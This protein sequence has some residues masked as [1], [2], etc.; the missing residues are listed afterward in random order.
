MFRV[1]IYGRWNVELCLYD[2]FVSQLVTP[3]IVES[4]AGNLSMPLLH[5]TSTFPLKT[6]EIKMNKFCKPPTIPSYMPGNCVS[7]MVCLLVTFNLFKRRSKFHISV[8]QIHERS[9]AIV[10][11]RGK[12]CYT[13]CPR[14]CQR[15]NAG[16]KRTLW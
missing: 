4:T 12:Q 11:Y 7:S 16:A 15:N 3:E 10:I 8:G 14:P 2:L 5:T 13:W 6:L 9:S 1:A